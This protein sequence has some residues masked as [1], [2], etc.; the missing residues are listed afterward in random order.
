[1][2]CGQGIAQE[3]RKGLPEPDAVSYAR[4]IESEYGERFPQA[5]E[6]LMEGLEDSLQYYD[7]PLLDS[8]KISSNN[9][10]ERANAQIRRRSRVVGVFPSIGW[11]V[12]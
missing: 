6:C 8:R 10:T 2:Q 9:G 1:V 12:A 5:M 4:E 11:Y 7:Y 3:Y